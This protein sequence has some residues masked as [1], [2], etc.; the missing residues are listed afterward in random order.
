MVRFLQTLLEKFFDFFWSDGMK[1]K[2]KDIAEHLNISVS[3]VSRVVNGKNYVNPEVR[4]KVLEALEY[5]QYRPNEIAR[6]L[7][8]KSSKVIG[9]IVPDIMNLFFTAIIKGVESEVREQDYSIMI[10]NSDERVDKEAEYLQLLAQ[11]QI[12]GLVIATVNESMPFLTDY[13]ALRIPVVFVDN[14]P[15]VSDQFDSVIVDNVKAS[16]EL[17]SRLIGKGHRDIA[18]I[19]GPLNQTT[20]SER[21]A[22]WE[23]AMREGGVTMRKEW[24]KVGTFK[25]QDGYEYMKALLESDERP[26]AVFAANNILAYGAIRAIK[27]KELRIP[28]DI[29]L[30]SFDTIDPTGLFS[31]VIASMIQPTEEIGRIAGDIIIRK[32][33]NPDIKR[34]ERVVLEPEYIEGGSVRSL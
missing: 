20:S 12:S 32:L 18:I 9:V 31:P 8:N 13:K 33:K 14:L 5:F 23:Q 24:V 10:C 26:T 17:V 16:H 2:L 28:E 7:K 21:L 15:K 11:K 4:K 30:I 6:S 3:T 25:Q 34:T 1:V 22:G 19:T 27:E 29:S